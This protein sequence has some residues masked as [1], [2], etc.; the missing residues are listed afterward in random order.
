MYLILLYDLAGQITRVL[1]RQAAQVICH[2]VG[3]LS[4][5]QS[6]LRPDSRPSVVFQREN[7]CLQVTL[8]PCSKTPKLFSLIHLRGLSKTLESIKYH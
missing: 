6:P 3:S 8:E 1:D 7:G 4:N 5:V 2:L